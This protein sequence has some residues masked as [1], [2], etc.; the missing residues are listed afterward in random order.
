M[1]EEKTFERGMTQGLPTAKR[2]L[3]E[4]Y[5]L[6]GYTYFPFNVID[7]LTSDVVA[8][9][10][11]PMSMELARKHKQS[12]PGLI[13]RSVKALYK[14]VCGENVSDTNG[15]L[16][17][18]MEHDVKVCAQCKKELSALPCAGCNGNTY[19]KPTIEHG[20]AFCANC[21]KFDSRCR[22]DMAQAQGARRGCGITHRLII[23]EKSL[24]VVSMA[25]RRPRE[26]DR[27]SGD[28]QG[29]TSAFG[30][31][32]ALTTRPLAVFKP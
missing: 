32:P 20:K 31:L 9:M 12:T 14:A 25:V 7:W 15:L 24:A 19:G 16:A 10:A 30:D 27:R 11:P 28:P 8:S 3:A 13:P 17:Q 23:P 29:R 21:M 6:K 1:P 22:A 4:K 5:N 26:S 18:A 2:R